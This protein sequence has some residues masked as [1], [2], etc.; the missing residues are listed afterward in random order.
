MRKELGDSG[1][2][3]KGSNQMD[4]VQYAGIQLINKSAEVY[5]EPFDFR[6]TEGKLLGQSQDNSG[7]DIQSIHYVFVVNKFVSGW[8]TYTCTLPR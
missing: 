3:K 7:Y 8:L 1:I 2:L 4:Q 5:V 6:K